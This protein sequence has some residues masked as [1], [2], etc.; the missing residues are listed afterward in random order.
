MNE[1]A[2]SRQYQLAGRS[3][4]ISST[5]IYHN[6]HALWIIMKDRPRVLSVEICGGAARA[7]A[8]GKSCRKPTRE[9]GCQ[10]IFTHLWK[11][12]ASESATRYKNPGRLTT[13]CE[14]SGAASVT[15]L[16]CQKISTLEGSGPYRFTRWE[17]AYQTHAVCTMSIIKKTC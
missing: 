16:G 10:Q 8:A 6:A 1:N 17:R 12:A 3:K 7:E 11:A 5:A 15:R 13:L 4:R 9:E 14:V 2:K